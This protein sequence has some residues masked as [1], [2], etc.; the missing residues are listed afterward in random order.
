MARQSRDERIDRRTM[1]KAVGTTGATAVGATTAT[2][3]AVAGDKDGDCEP[4]YSVPVV[5]TADHIDT[6]WWGS[7]HITDGN[8]AYNYDTA[9][10]PM[11]EGP[12][13]MV[14]HCHGWRNGPDCGYY[15]SELVDESYAQEE[16][17]GEIVGLVWD[18]TYTWWNAKQIAEKNALKLAS[19]IIDYKD[20]HPETTIRLQGHSLGARVVAETILELDRREAY[21]VLT[22]AIFLGGAIDNHSVAVD[23][24]YGPSIENVV[25]HAENFWMEEDSV[26]DYIYT[27]YEFSRAVGNS[28]VSG[29]PPA[30]WTDHHVQLDSHSDHYK[31]HSGLME[32][33]VQTFETEQEGDNII[34]DED[35]NVGENPDHEEDSSSSFCFITTATA[36]DVGT[37]N[38][39]R[40][41]RDDSMARS[42]VGRSLIRLYYRISPPIARTLEENPDSLTSRAVRSL[43]ERCAGLSEK[44]AST[45]SKAVSIA[46]GSM[47]TVLYI[48]GILIAGGGHAVH[49]SK[50]RGQSLVSSVRTRIASLVGR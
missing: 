25:Q 20:D 22:T 47:L 31:P 13:E 4:D 40:R 16:Y 3:P 43:V 15:R 1:L 48:Q 26:L 21:D 7:V 12:S 9:G 8:N 46:I 50:D 5:Y 23:G 45:D 44:Q 19:F 10:K 33:V 41:F 36:N 18:S 30:N 39:L 24:K 35:S 28:G 34:D 42:R 32:D 38:S 29:V 27:V 14:I 37:L 6:T 49:R 2:Q 17:D 11:P